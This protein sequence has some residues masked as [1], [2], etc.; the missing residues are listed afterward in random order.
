MLFFNKYMLDLMSKMTL[1]L[2]MVISLQYILWG[3]KTM[4]ETAFI[5]LYCLAFGFTIFASVKFL[6]AKD[7][8]AF[9]GNI[10]KNTSL[11]LKDSKK[12]MA[13][14]LYFALILY[15]TYDDFSPPVISGAN[16]NL[17]HDVF[18]TTVMFLFL[19]LAIRIISGDINKEQILKSFSGFIKFLFV[20]YI[21][22]SIIKVEG[23]FLYSL[24]EK[25]M[26]IFIFAVSI[27]LIACKVYS[28][29]IGNAYA[30]D[31]S[32]LVYGYGHA[33]LRHPLSIEDQETTIVHEVGHAMTVAALGFV[34]VGFSLVLKKAAASDESLGYVSGVASKD[35]VN[36]EAYLMWE[37][38]ML[39]GGIVAEK[40]LFGEC[41]S[42]GSSDLNKW[43]SLARIY[44]INQFAGFYYSRPEDRTELQ[45]NIF[46]MSELREKQVL[47]LNLLFQENRAVFLEMMES[48]RAS[49]GLS[50]IELVTL[51]SKV[52]LPETFPQ[53]FGKIDGFEPHPIDKHGIT[54]AK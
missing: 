52:V 13:M 26:P 27:M 10:F 29:F 24:L 53:P 32:R 42:G 14:I 41:K 37:M 19:I 2:T 8:K 50:D 17:I 1:L 30:P 54:I 45:H 6:L 21:L 28:Y 9:L 15:I 49:G 18:S 46:V 31:T 22:S 7:K 36:S 35:R 48:S 51:L 38:T 3:W 12:D 25:N 43:E 16:A 33:A 5:A 20:V 39:L 23:E 34:P 11:L 47:S 4:D 40:F 44:M